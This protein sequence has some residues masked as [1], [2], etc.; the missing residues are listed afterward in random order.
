MASQSAGAKVLDRGWNGY[1]D[2]TAPST[3]ML[4][5]KGDY[6]ESLVVYINPMGL[7]LLSESFTLLLLSF[8]VFTYK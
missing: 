2:L 7:P 1:M 5:S 6:Q 3:M 8:I 4:V